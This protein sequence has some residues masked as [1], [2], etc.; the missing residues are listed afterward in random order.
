MSGLLQ[1]AEPK[2][3]RF[4]VEAS[5]EPFEYKTPSGELAGFDI[6]IG[7]LVCRKLKVR[8]VWVE[9]TLDGLI[10]SLISRKF[11]AI[12]SDLTI[13]SQRLKIVDFTD[14]IY[15]VQNKLIARNDSQLAP[16]AVALK[17]KRIGVLQG[18]IQE[19]FAL[20]RWAPAGA[21]IESYQTQELAYEDLKNGR[22]DATFQEAE[23]GATGFLGKPYAREFGFKGDA[24]ED[25]DTL[26]G[27]TGFAVRKSD[28][29]LKAQLNQALRELKQDGTIGRLASKYFTV[30]V[31]VEASP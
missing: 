26:G 20:K 19:T 24:V 5:Y 16:E 30:P 8:C 22:L 27:G 23:A 6:D 21:R 14:P 28:L 4:G 25:R 13:T 29:R 11:D 1:A 9:S 7:N 18:S 31:K 10:P 3:L 15:S 12:N 2:T 17:G